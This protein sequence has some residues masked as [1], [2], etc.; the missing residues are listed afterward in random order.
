MKKFDLTA[1]RRYKAP[2]ISNY[3]AV[4]GKVTSIMQIR[5]IQKDKDTGKFYSIFAAGI[6]VVPLANGNHIIISTLGFYGF[7]FT[8]FVERFIL[9]LIHVH[10]AENGYGFI[11]TD[12][13]DVLSTWNY[14]DE[15][16]VINENIVEPTHIDDK[17]L[18][19]DISCYATL[20]EFVEKLK[21]NSL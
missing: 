10:R 15:G 3:V 1:L 4:I 9:D 12:D 18:L 8:E 6:D 13:S 20:D 5:T 2:K 7:T 21:I 11:L 14:D 19:G 16:N 17:N